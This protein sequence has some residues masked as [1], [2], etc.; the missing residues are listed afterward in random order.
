MAARALFVAV[1]AVAAVI[2]TSA[3]AT[4][5]KSWL[6]CPAGERVG[7][8][9]EIA[10]A[11]SKRYY[12]VD[13][14]FVGRSPSNEDVDRLLRECLAIA[15]KRD[16][17]KDILASPWMRKRSTAPERDD[18]LLHPYVYEHVP[19]RPSTAGL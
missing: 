5:A 19:H 2:V 15:V 4:V 11:A 14:T 16:G 6:P 17:S 1:Y 10:L 18:D 8:T 9:T 3:H 7:A 12:T 13:V